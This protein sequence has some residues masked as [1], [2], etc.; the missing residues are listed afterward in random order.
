[1]LNLKTYPLTD[2]TGRMHSNSMPILEDG[3]SSGHAS[4]TESNNASLSI[5][6][7]QC[8]LKDINNTTS[9]FISTIQN[10]MQRNDQ[11]YNNDSICELTN[12]VLV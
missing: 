5:L 10:S 8:R 1:L 11:Q 4:D 9:Q 12:K 2:S 3:L 6:I 7:E